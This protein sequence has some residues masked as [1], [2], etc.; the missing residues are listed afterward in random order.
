MAKPPR[1]GEVTANEPG[2][3]DWSQMR[4]NQ[5]EVVLTQQENATLRTRLDQRPK[6]HRHS[7]WRRK[8]ESDHG[9]L[10]AACNRA[11]SLSS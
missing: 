4:T 9:V 5:S 6:S 11:S 3:K 2:S 7:T 8:K 1:R 10:R